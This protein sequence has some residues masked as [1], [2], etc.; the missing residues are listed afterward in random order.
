MNKRQQVATHRPTSASP[1]GITAEGT[2]VRSRRRSAIVR[3][4]AL[5]SPA[6]FVGCL[7][8]RREA[9]RR[10]RRRQSFE[11]NRWS[12]LARRPHRPVAEQHHARLPFHENADALPIPSRAT[13]LLVSDESSSHARTCGLHPDKPRRDER[14]DPLLWTQ[15][16][17]RSGD[18]P[19]ARC[20]DTVRSVRT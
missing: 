1:A 6:T 15:A 19:I 9:C 7:Q 17:E 8:H 2:I 5:T 16:D 4:P 14:I 20:A 13:E 11:Q 10:A 3:T 18:R 12:D